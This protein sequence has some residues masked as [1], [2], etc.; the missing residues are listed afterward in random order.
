MGRH[1]DLKL[2]Y[3]FQRLSKEGAE[4]FAANLSE[5]RGVYNFSP[6]SFTRAI[7]QYQNTSRNPELHVSEVDRESTGAFVQFLFSYKVNPQTVFFL[8]YSDNREGSLDTAFQRVPLT[9]LDRTFFLKLGY[10]WRP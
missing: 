9:Q 1:I 5:L 6:R 4:I 8:G 10:A 2:S 7:L 3:R